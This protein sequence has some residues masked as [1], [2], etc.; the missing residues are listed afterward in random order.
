MLLLLAFSVSGCPGDAT[1]LKLP[2][3]LE[4]QL[5]DRGDP[6]LK[7]ALL[8]N[9][10]LPFAVIVRFRTPVFPEQAEMLSDAGIPPVETVGKTALIVATAREISSLI[11]SP[12]VEKIRY[13]G[14]QAS[15]ARLHPTLEIGLIRIF[16]EGREKDPIDLLIRFRSPPDAREERLL[17][18]ARFAIVTRAGIIWT[19]R[20]ATLDLP[21]LLTIDEII[22]YEAASKT[23]VM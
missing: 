7:N 1:L 4:R 19:V 11:E 13:L 18:A 10:P 12:A 20:G 9:S 8:A 6:I 14:S 22:Y 16:E 5:T 15:L 21:A 2:P 3:S 23:R 17:T